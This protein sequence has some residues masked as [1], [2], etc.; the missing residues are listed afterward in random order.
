MTKS[1]L[2]EAYLELRSRY[3]GVYRNP[4][5]EM[6]TLLLFLIALIL[7]ERGDK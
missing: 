5:T 1:E 6:I 2:R 4:E 7:L 3:V